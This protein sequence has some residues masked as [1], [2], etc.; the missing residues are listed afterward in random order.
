[1]L[2]GDQNS[3]IVGPFVDRSAFVNTVDAMIL[4]AD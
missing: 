1:M 4:P 3:R 2:T